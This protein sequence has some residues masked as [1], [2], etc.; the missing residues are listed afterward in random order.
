MF[1]LPILTAAWWAAKW[2]LGLDRARAAASGPFA[3]A[4][5]ATA[6]AFVV[7]VAIALGLVWL[8]FDAR[9]DAKVACDVAEYQR[10]LAVAN[11]IANSRRVANR[12]LQATLAVR[13]AAAATDE[14]FIATLEKERAELRAKVAAGDARVLFK[15]GDPWLAGKGGR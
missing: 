15:A 4:I 2:G 9:R 10:R 8:R 7:M 13:E 5:A 1:G 12:Q 14:E 11:A 3:K 6:A